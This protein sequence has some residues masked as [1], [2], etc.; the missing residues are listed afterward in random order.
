MPT[1][2]AEAVGE[3][4]LLHSKLLRE[5]Y[6][7]HLLKSI[8]RPNRS[9]TS[10]SRRLVSMPVRCNLKIFHPI[11]GVIKEGSVLQSDLPQQ[12]F[13]AR[14]APDRIVQRFYFDLQHRI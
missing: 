10:D 3:K 9:S 14:I 7:P 5:R 2:V 4:S 6:P 12:T 1:E 8:D 11:G 13:K